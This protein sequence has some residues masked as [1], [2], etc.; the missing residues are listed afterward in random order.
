MRL[1]NLEVIFETAPSE[2]K[3]RMIIIASKY[4]QI[5]LM[6]VEF[7]FNGRRSFKKW[8]F[9]QTSFMVSSSKIFSLFSC[10][11]SDSVECTDDILHRRSVTQFDKLSAQLLI[12]RIFHTMEIRSE[13]RTTESNLN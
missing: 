1:N 12:A 13:N 8:A 7:C 4:H 2:E 6:S 5:S 11:I 9:D 3:R 10:S